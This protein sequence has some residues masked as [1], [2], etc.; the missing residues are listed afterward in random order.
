MLFL[1]YFSNWLDTFHWLHRISVGLH[2]LSGQG[3]TGYLVGCT[4]YMVGLHRLYGV[5]TDNNAQ[6][7]AL[8]E[9]DNFLQQNPTK[10]QFSWDQLQMNFNPSAHIP[11]LSSIP[12]INKLK[13]NWVK[14]DWGQTSLWQADSNP[15]Q[16]Q[17]FSCLQLSSCHKN[18]LTPEIRPAQSLG[19]RE[20][21][22]QGIS[23]ETQFCR[24]FSWKTH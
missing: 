24:E 3:C 10:T 14:L 15:K 1:R 18:N 8:L 11:S 13:L 4:G 12:E 20:N 23:W 17:L 16:A 9:L 6:A 2:R 5:K 22:S 19:S 7:L 21:I